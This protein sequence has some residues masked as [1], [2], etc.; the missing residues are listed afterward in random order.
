MVSFGDAIGLFFRRYFDFTGRSSRSAYWWFQLFYFLT[1]ILFVV[2]VVITGMDVDSEE[3]E[4]SGAVSLFAF[5]L[6]V[7]GT[8]IGQISL[9]VRRFHDLNQTGWLVL[10]FIIGGLI[11]LIGLLVSLAQII[12]FVMPGTVG[13]NRYGPDSLMGYDSNRVL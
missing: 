13:N 1:L 7:L 3:I 8:F 10:V 12:W 6:F 9:S 11:P 5:A 4:T 2:S